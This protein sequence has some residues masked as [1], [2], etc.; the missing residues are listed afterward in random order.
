MINL[1]AD[2]TC[3]NCGQV[4]VPA[5][6]CDPTLADTNGGTTCSQTL[7]SVYNGVQTVGGHAV[8]QGPPRPS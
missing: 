2:G 4:V 3:A 6:A 5:S 7:G 1:I 8:H